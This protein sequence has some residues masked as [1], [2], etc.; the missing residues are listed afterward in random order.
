MRAFTTLTATA[1]LALG[2]AACSSEQSGTIEGDD[3]ETGDYSI[4]TQT[5]EATATITTEDGT[6]T[7]RSGESVPVDLPAGFTVYPGAKITGNTTVNQGDGSGTIVTLTTSDSAKQV[8]DFYRDQAEKAG[9][10]I[11]MNMATNGGQIVG[12]QSED[13]LTF[14]LLATPTPDGSSAQLTVGQELGSN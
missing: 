13:G 6:V 9:I 1:A 12:G 10:A 14:S 3:G 2:L 5:G 11:Q 4:D 8:A 7:L